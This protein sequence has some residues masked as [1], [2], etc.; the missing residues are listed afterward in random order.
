M[1]KSNMSRIES[2]KTSPAIFTLY[3]IATKLEVDFSEL[4]I[5][6]EKSTK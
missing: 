5:F 1:E 6:P 3:T 4:F 2:G